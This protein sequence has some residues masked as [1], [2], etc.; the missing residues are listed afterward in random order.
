MRFL[1]LSVLI[2]CLGTM[3]FAG[4]PIEETAKCPFG[5]ERV[6]YISSPGCSSF[7]GSMRM[8]LAP[9][10]SCD[11]VERLP[12][13][14]KSKVPLYRDFSKAE[15]KR[16]KEFSK[17]E[18]YLEASEISRFYLAYVIERELSPDAVSSQLD[19]LVLGLWYDPERT[20]NN[21]IYFR[22]FSEVMNKVTPSASAE[23]KAFLR[24]IGAYGLVKRGNLSKAK[25]MIKAVRQSPAS[26]GTFLPAYLT[27]LE[28]CFGRQAA[29]EC[30]PDYEVEFE[31]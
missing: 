19:L 20:Y 31:E 16:L 4:M 3:A 25:E 6:K 15:A 27:L 29:P 10:T 13:C 23:D 30:Q 17:S 24:A 18:I 12:Q 14:P 22:A 1:R 28:K 26:K 11:F 7:G 8:S 9:I 5:G 2:V 21:D